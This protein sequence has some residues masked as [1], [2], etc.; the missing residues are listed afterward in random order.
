MVIIIFIQILIIVIVIVLLIVLLLLLLL[1]I[2]IMI[3]NTTVAAAE[4]MDFGRLGNRYFW[5]DKHALMG[6]PNKYHLSNKKHTI[7]SDPISVDPIT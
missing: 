7:R 3:V 5:G 6:V 2:I 1:L 4:V